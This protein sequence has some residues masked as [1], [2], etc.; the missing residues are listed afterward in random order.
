MT[1]PARAAQAL[2]DAVDRQRRQREVA[3]DP[4]KLEPAG[5]LGIE[6]PDEGERQP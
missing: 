6:R 3:I 5:E 1:Q 2:Q 4:R